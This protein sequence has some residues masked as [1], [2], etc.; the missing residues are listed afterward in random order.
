L[1]LKSDTVY[2]VVNDRVAAAFIVHLLG[3]NTN[4]FYLNFYS[5]YIQE[6]DSTLEKSVDFSNSASI[7][8]LLENDSSR[9]TYPCT[10]LGV[11]TLVNEFTREG[12]KHYE[13]FELSERSAVLYNQENT[14]GGRK[15]LLFEGQIGLRCRMCKI[16]AALNTRGTHHCT[17]PT[18]LSGMKVM[19][20][21][22]IRDHLVSENG[23]T[24]IDPKRRDH[25]HNL[26]L[27]KQNSKD[28]YFDHILNEC[29]LIGLYDAPPNDI[30]GST[31]IRWNGSRA[32]HKEATEPDS[33]GSFQ[34][35]KDDSSSGSDGDDEEIGSSEDD[36]EEIKDSEIDS[37]KSNGTETSGSR[38]Q[39]M[40]PE[41]VSGRRRSLRARTNTV[42]NELSSGSDTSS[43]SDT[44]S[45][46]DTS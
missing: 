18:K 32:N 42:Y 21:R 12:L 23:C 28:G 30:G 38:S 11:S 3:V 35:D 44:S 36:C 40:E 25:L 33:F 41:Y 15:Y 43:S 14:R 39:S 6:F 17:F 5:L 27:A 37:F 45:N 16:V 20:P 26:A 46:W 34:H 10:S 7:V 19:L 13:F 4:P 8:D 22:M 9:L 29:A 31:T 24:V 2:S 1:T